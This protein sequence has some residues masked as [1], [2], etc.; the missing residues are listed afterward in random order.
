[1]GVDP[2]LCATGWGVVDYDGFHLRHVDHGVITSRASDEIGDRLAFIFRKL[3]DVIEEK[4]P[5]EVSI[6]QVF[7]NGNPGASLKLGMARGVAI[8]VPSV[9]GLRVFGYAPN[10]VKKTVVGCGH[11]SKEQ[12]SMMVQ[13]LLNC[14]AVKS[15][16]ADALAIAVCHAHHRSIENI[17]KEAV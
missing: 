12:V 16:A 4:A 3:S 14:S 6:E 5:H 17:R 9:M 7:V 2:G 1:L 13:K 8:C 15:D 10:K 11:A